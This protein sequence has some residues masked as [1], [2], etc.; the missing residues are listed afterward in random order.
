MWLS[1]S[2]ISLVNLVH[3]L[4]ADVETDS[5]EKMRKWKGI[6]AFYLKSF[7]SMFSAMATIVAIKPHNLELLIF[8]LTVYYFYSAIYSSNN[9][10][11]YI[12]LIT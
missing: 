10:W 1:R 11:I 9:F 6:I 12:A 5:R 4:W 7:S 2:A 8:L 3:S